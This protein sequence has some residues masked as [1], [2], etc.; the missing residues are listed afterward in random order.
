MTTL[1]KTLGLYSLA[2]AALTGANARADDDCE[3][4]EARAE[5]RVNAFFKPR[6]DAIQTHLTSSSNVESRPPHHRNSH[7]RGL[8]LWEREA[9][10]PA[11]PDGWVREDKW[12]W[13]ELEAALKALPPG[14]PLARWSELYVKARSLEL[15]DEDRYDRPGIYAID[16]AARDALS[17]EERD[18][19]G[20]PPFE[21]SGALERTGPRRYRVWLAAGELGSDRAKIQS[22][23]ARYWG[24]A[25]Y[26]LSVRWT[27]DAIAATGL[28]GFA[29][30]GIFLAGP[31]ERSYVSDGDRSVNLAFPLRDSTL[32]HEVG[33]VLGLA[34]NYHTTWDEKRCRYVVESRPSDL[35]SSSKTGVALREHWEL[36]ERELARFDAKSR[37]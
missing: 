2:I 33:H 34:D 22:I 5:R 26:A 31:G 3:T 7:L 13:R 21:P 35:M 27:E 10:S 30:Y 15:D 28:E 1:R 11:A 9:S 36:I 29:P 12:S 14:A 23:V 24:V 16:R 17:R 25:G 20:L 32:A 37:D 8:P 18:E 6:T 4:L 19:L